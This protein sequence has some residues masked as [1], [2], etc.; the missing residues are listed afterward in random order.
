MS[1]IYF[2]RTVPFY[3]TDKPSFYG[4]V[5]DVPA[6]ALAQAQELRVLIDL[7]EQAI[8]NSAAPERSNQG[9]AESFA[10]GLLAIFKAKKKGA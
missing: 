9:I 2:D 10:E 4:T 8:I 1:K 3:L 6:K 5:V 7:T